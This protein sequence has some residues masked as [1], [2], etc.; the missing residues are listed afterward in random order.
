MQAVILAAGQGIR[1]RPM[2]SFIPKC[3][4]KVGKK[5][6]LEHTFSQLPNE[7]HEV[8]IVVGHLQEQIRKYFGRN[9]CG[10]PIRYI[11]QPEKLGTGHALFIC[12]NSLEDKKF[13]V[14]MGDDLYLKKRHQKMSKA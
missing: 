1:L 10:R 12:K 11:E 14:M 5:P 9:F 3:L 8:I 13:L 4:L 2:T 6:I 7:I